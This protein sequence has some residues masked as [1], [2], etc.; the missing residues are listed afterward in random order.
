MPS[1][2][3]SVQ[4]QC[5]FRRSASRQSLCCEGF[6]D[7]CTVSVYFAGPEACRLHKRIFCNNL[8]SNCEVYRMVF[9]AKY[10]DCPPVP[11][12]RV[13]VVARRAR[14]NAQTRR[15]YDAHPSQLRTDS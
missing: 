15:K 6:T 7:A 1:N 4:C 3:D 2:Q 14:A 13:R 9:E 10:A 8:F 12:G 5:P 11:T